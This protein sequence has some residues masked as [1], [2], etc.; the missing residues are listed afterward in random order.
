MGVNLQKV[1]RTL[2]CYSDNSGEA[3]TE[4]W[5]SRLDKSDVIQK[6]NWLEK[7]H[8]KCVKLLWNLL[9]AA[10]RVL[11]IGAHKYLPPKVVC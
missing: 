11:L 2:I 6:I 1:A 4:N 5:S 7:T 9:N 8:G 10:Y 3:I